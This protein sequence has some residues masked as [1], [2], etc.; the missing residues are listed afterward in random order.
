MKHNRI[1]LTCMLWV[2]LAIGANAAN[3][4]T[5]PV[6]DVVIEVIHVNDDDDSAA[7]ANEVIDFN[8]V[9]TDSGEL[10]KVT[11]TLKKL[12]DQESVDKYGSGKLKAV[13]T[14]KNYVR[15]WKNADRSE[16]ITL[17]DKTIFVKDVS[18]GMTQ[19]YVEIF[20]VEGIK[21]TITKEDVIIEAGYTVDTAEI[22]KDTAKTGVWQV[23][24][25]V[26]SE[27]KAIPWNKKDFTRGIDD[28]ADAIEAS[29]EDNH[30][31]KIYF[32]GTQPDVDGDGVPDWGDGYGVAGGK[33][34]D[35]GQFLPVVVELPE[36]YDMSLAKVQ[37]GYTLSPL[38]TSTPA[39]G[40]VWTIPSAGMRLW[41]KDAIE[42][43]TS[44]D[45]IKPDAAGIIKWSDLAG[46]SRKVTLYIEAV[47]DGDFYGRKELKITV[48]GDGP[49]SVEDKVFVHIL[50]LKLMAHKRGSIQNPG[51]LIS[52]KEVVT[53][54]NADLD[55]FDHEDNARALTPADVSNSEL[56]DARKN[57]SN[58]QKL[59]AGA[60]EF[61]ND[62]VKLYCDSSLIPK[63]TK[64]TIEVEIVSPAGT[65]AIS[66]D[67]IFFYTKDGNKVDL[68]QLKLANAEIPTSGVMHDLFNKSRGI[69]VELGDLGSA[70][71]NSGQ[72]EINHLK[73]CTVRLQINGN[74]SMDAI[75]LKRGGFWIY[76]RTSNIGLSFNDGVVDFKTTGAVD[77][78]DEGVMLYGPYETKSGRPGV[79]DDKTK[80]KGPTPAGWWMLTERTGSSDSGSFAWRGNKWMRSGDTQSDRTKFPYPLT[81]PKADV[82]KD[83]TPRVYQGGY[84]I[85][86]VAGH[87]VAGQR[88]Y[89][90]A[91]DGE[92]RPIPLMFKFDLIKMLNSQ[93]KRDAIQI[94]PDGHNDGTLGCIGLQIYQEAIRTNYLLKQFR[95]IP[96][97]VRGTPSNSW[98][99]PPE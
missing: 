91:T 10:S 28:T 84:S 75:K 9:D 90:P 58:G 40:A 48:T 27:N 21:H 43:R 8:E 6:I 5:P 64:L 72:T 71:E 46:S 20:Y 79:N 1:L 15:I 47:S 13:I 41:K 56:Q 45:L 36:P 11:I 19:D 63:D 39:E 60:L 2:T 18:I 68:S 51:A 62:F 78:L 88:I 37:F 61:D 57:R 93:T 59:T 73:E 49:T 33:F 53:I 35:K 92:T 67:K 99:T 89:D 86:N 24:L 77:K 69:F 96:I 95:A 3:H 7:G 34:I 65:K 14:G 82:G 54:E 25:D 98:N 29:I 81:D 52:G 38:L 22:A 55:Q 44:D 87:F 97:S 30:P 42:E 12:L 50:P 76:D 4:A 32:T 94:H 31:G 80:N 83:Q 17:S 70:S 26:D 85:W 16:L 74:T 66:T 23:D